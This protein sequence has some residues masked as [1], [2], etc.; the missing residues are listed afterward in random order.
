MCTHNPWIDRTNYDGSMVC[1]AQSM[2]CANPYFVPNIYYT[3]YV[4]KNATICK[5]WSP[6]SDK[7][8][9]HTFM[10]SP[11]FVRE[12]WEYGIVVL[13]AKRTTFSWQKANMHVHDLKNV[14]TF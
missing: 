3:V 11:G 14:I 1:A 10:A 13:F 7:T 5:I 9:C 6:Q 8:T 12:A 4:K 2:D